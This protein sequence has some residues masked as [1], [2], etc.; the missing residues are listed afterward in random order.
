MF[1]ELIATFSAGFGAAG[2]VLIINRLTGGRLPGWSMPVGAGAAMLAVAILNEYSWGQRTAAGLPEGI[3]VVEKVRE[4]NW[5]RPWSFAAPVTT[6]LSALDTA[7]VQTNP[8]APDLRLADLYLFGRWRPAAR[9]PQLI[10]C[11]RGA[12][13]DVT[14]AVLANPETALWQD[15]NPELAALACPVDAIEMETT[16]NG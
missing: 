4:S 11:E 7:T 3:V 15:A 5:Y 2:L 9:V 12:R 10:H 13:A 16:G 1:L 14:D 8:Q 6:R